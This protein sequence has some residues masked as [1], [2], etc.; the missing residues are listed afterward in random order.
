MI[1]SITQQKSEEEIDQLL[2][3][4][5]RVFIFGCGTCVT[6]T[7]TGGRPEVDAMLEELSA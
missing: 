7:H 4:F 1:R 6:M 3:G 2:D 5:G